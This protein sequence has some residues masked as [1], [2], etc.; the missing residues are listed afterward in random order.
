MWGFAGLIGLVELGGF[1]GFMAS[2]YRACGG[3]RQYDAFKQ[4]GGS[5][6]CSKCV[7]FEGAGVEGSKKRYLVKRYT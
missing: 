5:V 1:I 6:A 7:G 4:G 2:R 3:F